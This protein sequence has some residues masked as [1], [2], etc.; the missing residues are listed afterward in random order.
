MTISKRKSIIWIVGIISLGIISLLLLFYS[1]TIYAAG[2]TFYVAPYDPDITT[3]GDG[4]YDNPWRNLQDVIN[5]KVE[6]LVPA[7]FPYDGTGELIIKNEGAPVKAGD[8]II[9]KDGYHGQIKISRIFNEDYITIKSENKNH[10]VLSRLYLRGS[11]YW[12]FSGLTI[13]REFEI[14]ND[15]GLIKLESH[16]WSGPVHHVTIEE[17]K[18]HSFED[19]SQWTAD[20]W[21]TKASTGIHS[22]GNYITVINNDLK[23][24]AHGIIFNG[25]NSKAINNV[26]ENF[27]CDGMRGVG[28]DLLFENNLIKNCY[29]TGNGNH[30]DGFQSFQYQGDPSDRI[31]LRGN[32]IIDHE[33]P[34]QPLKGELQGIGCFDGPFHGWIIENNVIIVDHWHGI[35]MSGAYNSLIVNNTVI[36]P[37]GGRSAWIRISN[38]KDN[39]GGNPSENVIVR[40]NI[41][42]RFSIGEGTIIF[43]H[44]LEITE[45]DYEKIFIN[46]SDSED[47][48]LHLKPGSIAINTGSSELA[49]DIDIEGNQR[50]YGNVYDIGAYEYQGE[51]DPPP[52]APTNLEIE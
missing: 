50:P 9:L 48:D 51:L 24:V 12:V 20:D 52:A 1:T 2:N 19:S 38:L 44:N 5:N 13:N 6:S 17:C 10:A 31:T 39:L 21:N 22:L 11:S 30:D 4:S 26:I 27:S 3:E 33:D 34:N 8:T 43:D 47:Y 23:N 40:N 16:N 28:D 36:S 14:P 49:P 37:V 7:K 29:G 41:T 32:I 15:S 42:K 25:N 46:T 35:T 18:L 45:D